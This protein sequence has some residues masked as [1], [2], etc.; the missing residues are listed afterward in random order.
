LIGGT[1]QVSRHVTEAAGKQGAGRRS[2]DGRP[3]MTNIWLPREPPAWTG[4]HLAFAA[5]AESTHGDRPKPL[6]A[7]RPTNLV[8]H[9]HVLGPQAKGPCGDSCGRRRPPAWSRRP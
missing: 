6:T 8:S 1:A 9:P 4:G 3:T 7:V 2:E 5:S